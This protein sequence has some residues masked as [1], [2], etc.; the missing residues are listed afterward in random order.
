[1]RS[2]HQEPAPPKQTLLRFNPNHYGPGPQGGQFAPA[3]AGDS[4]ESDA[5]STQP[6]AQTTQEILFGRAPIFLDEPPV[7][8]PPPLSE[9]PTDPTKPPGPGFEWKGTNPEPGSREGSWYN[10]QTKQTLRP[11]LDHPPGVEPHWDYKAPN[12]KTYRWYS[13]GRMELK[14]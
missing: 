10:E 4:G 7:E 11:D 6:R 8:I 9:Y 13:D 12:G 1:M 2:Q 3:D 14:P 5:G